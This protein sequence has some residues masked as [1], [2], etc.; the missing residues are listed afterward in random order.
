[1]VD[2]GNIRT[3][4]LNL[5]GKRYMKDANKYFERLLNEY[6]QTW[7]DKDI[8]KLKDYYDIKSNRLIYYDNHKGNDTYTL[9]DHLALISD[10]F[11]NG[12]QTESGE[13]E[14]LIIEN[15]NVFS[16]GD[17]ACLCFITRY[18]SFPN[19]YIRATM[20]LE[21]IQD[22]WKVIHVHCSFEPEK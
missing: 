9:E 16:K 14:E 18:K 19:P 21:I 6:N 7:Y 17:T 11:N 10:F 20:Y 13:I 15:F 5:G 12:K 2:L 3:T 8:E 22:K 1:M 4:N